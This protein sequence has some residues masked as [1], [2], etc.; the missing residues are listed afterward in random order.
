MRSY[1][2]NTDRIV[3]QLVPHYLGGR[4]LILFLQAILQPL[5]S[6][7][8]KWKEWADEKRIEAAMTSQVIMMEYFLN[9]KFR[10]YFL[11]TSEHIVISDGAI[12]GVPYIG[13]ML[14]KIYANFLCITKAK[15]KLPNTQPLHYAGKMKKYQQVM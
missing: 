10:K 5:N 15:T 13:K 7:N 3:N 1:R 9:H 2:I 14:I 11:N 12:N 8:I 4:K 6:L